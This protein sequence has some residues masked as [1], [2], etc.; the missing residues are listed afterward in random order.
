MCQFSAHFRRQKSPWISSDNIVQWD[1][2]KL[3]GLVG[4]LHNSKIV[5]LLQALTLLVFKTYQIREF[6]C[7][8]S[9]KLQP[10]QLALSC[11]KDNYFLLNSRSKILCLAYGLF[12]LHQ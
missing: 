1:L 7:F 5:T 6:D 11:L 4:L 9:L 8:S 3:I 10:A 2:V 12:F